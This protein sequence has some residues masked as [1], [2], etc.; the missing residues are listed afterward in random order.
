MSLT[1]VNFKKIN[2]MCSFYAIFQIFSIE[3][4]ESSCFCV[5]KLQTSQK[6]MLEHFSSFRK[7]THPE[8]LVSVARQYE[9]ERKEEPVRP[10][11]CLQ[12]KS[13]VLFAYLGFKYTGSLPVLVISI[14]TP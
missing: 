11:V 2:E 3:D 5:V 6:L 4:L 7:L 1:H 10:A 13:C 8:E 14:P 9:K 12:Q